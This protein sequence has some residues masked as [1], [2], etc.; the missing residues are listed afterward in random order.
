M[1]SK[2]KFWPHHS[3]FLLLL[4]AYIAVQADIG[5]V[6]IALKYHF[7]KCLTIS[8]TLQTNVAQLLQ[9]IK[10]SLYHCLL[11]REPHRETVYSNT[12]ERTL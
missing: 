5:N 6:H 4:S 2:M 9:C 11:F 3:C 12:S 7:H 10:S 1:C 8:N